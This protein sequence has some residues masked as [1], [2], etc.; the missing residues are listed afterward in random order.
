MRDWGSGKRLPR[1]KAKMRSMA[2]ALSRVD[3]SQLWLWNDHRLAECR[4]RALLLR[5]DEPRYGGAR[6]TWEP[7]KNVRIE[8]RVGCGVVEV[9]CKRPTA[10][11]CAA[12]SSRSKATTLDD[13]YEDE[14]C[15]EE[16]PG[17]AAATSSDWRGVL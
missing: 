4:T 17:V 11:E 14:A 13:L 2:M 9:H 5:G 15:G 8:Y 16:L 1:A 3:P 10:S 6:V 12:S 7:A